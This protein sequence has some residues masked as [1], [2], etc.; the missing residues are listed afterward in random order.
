M[1]TLASVCDYCNSENVRPLHDRA[2]ECHYHEVGEPCD[3]QCCMSAWFG[4]K[5]YGEDICDAVV[6]ANCGELT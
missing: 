4:S 5:D 2:S 3:D 6:C 1:R